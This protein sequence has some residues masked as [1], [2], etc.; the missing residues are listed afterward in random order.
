MKKRTNSFKENINTSTSKLISPKKKKPPHDDD[1]DDDFISL[2]KRPK[3]IHSSTPVPKID[4]IKECL[5]SIILQIENADAICPIC[6]QILSNFFTIDQRE[7]HVNHCLE[8]SQM[9]NVKHQKTLLS[10]PKFSSSIRKPTSSV[11]FK[12]QICGMSSNVKRT[13]LLHL[14]KCSAQN[15]IQLKHVVNFAAKTTTTV[16][17]VMTKKKTE[18]NIKSR[19]IKMEIPINEDDE[20]QQLAIALS[21]SIKTATEPPNAF[22]ILRAESKKTKTI[23][24]LTTPLWNVSIEDKLKL[25]STR[26]LNLCERVITIIPSTHPYRFPPSSLHAISQFN[27]GHVNWWNITTTDPEND[28]I[29][30]TQLARILDENDDEPVI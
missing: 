26:L 28:E 25:S 16:K 3:I 7:Q 18:M 9:Q 27:F 30:M 8:Q 4:P 14:K 11:I 5:E 10:Y 22:D 20:Q 24:L 15:S 19:V 12:C 21:A 13:Y 23:D 2:K 6:N 1:D 17:P 29:P